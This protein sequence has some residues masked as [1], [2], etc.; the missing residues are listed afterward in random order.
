MLDDF[1]K[2]L[3]PA[4]TTQDGSAL[5]IL[6]VHTRWNTAIVQ[7]LVDGAKKTMIEQ[8]NVKPEN[9]VIESVPGA[10]E[11]P[12]AAKK[13]LEV[14]QIRAAEGASDLIGNV[15]LLD[16]LNLSSP[17]TT[18]TTSAGAPPTSAGAATGAKGSRQAFD[19][20]ICI[21]VL[22]KGST[23]HFEYICEAVSQG[24]MRV[25]LDSGVP[26]IF[27]VLT[28]LN[29]E[30]ALSRAGLDKAGKGHNHGIDW[31]SGAVEMALLKNRT[32]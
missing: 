27:G 15:N 18:S 17:T 6:I 29:E 19:A 9:I 12:F 14:S 25:G 20:V 5:R 28:C 4:T 31:G 7:G 11:L 22:I 1:H 24:I 10:Y 13:L 23:M 2:G 26:V 32:L 16:G 30:Q 3:E 8:H 21:G